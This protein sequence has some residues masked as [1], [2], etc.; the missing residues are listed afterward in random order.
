ME[1]L[2]ERSI[3]DH[4]GNRDLLCS[5]GSDVANPQ[6]GSRQQASSDLAALGRHFLR[7][8]RRDRVGLGRTVLCAGALAEKTLDSQEVNV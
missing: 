1:N 6:H 5:A 2:A 7:H 4:C 8:R 3:S